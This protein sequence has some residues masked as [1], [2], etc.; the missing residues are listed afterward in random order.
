MDLLEPNKISEE[1]FSLY[2]QIV[3]KA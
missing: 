2:K 1:Y 3:W